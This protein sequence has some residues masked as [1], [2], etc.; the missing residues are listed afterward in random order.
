MFAEFPYC[1]VTMTEGVVS[2]R[3]ETA[4]LAMASP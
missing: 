1:E 4:T 2:T 3:L